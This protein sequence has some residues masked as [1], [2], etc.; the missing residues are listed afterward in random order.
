MSVTSIAIVASGLWTG[1]TSASAAPTPPTPVTPTTVKA[2]PGLA[3]IEVTWK[4]SV[5]K[6][7]TFTVTS[8]PI[9]K[10]CSVV[11]QLRCGVSV[12]DSTPWQFHVTASIGSTSSAPST[13]TAPVRHRILLILAGQSNAMGAESYPVDPTTGVNYLAPPYT[14]GADSLSTLSWYPWLV[15]PPKHPGKTGQVPLDTAQWLSP[16][17]APKVQIFGPEIGWARQV[18]SD[19]GQAVSIVK[20][21]AIGSLTVDWNPATPSNDFSVLLYRAIST[22]TDDAKSGQLDTIGAVAWY[23]GESDASTPADAAAYRANLTAFV[24]AFRADLPMDPA[25]PV[26]LV[27]ESMAGYL[28]FVQDTGGCATSVDCA[29]LQLGDSEVRSADDWVAGNLPHVTAVDTVDLPRTGVLVHLSNLGDLAV[30]TRIAQASDRSM[31]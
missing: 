1:V 14:N 31:P 27:K 20:V 5:R 24:T 6:G 13:L 22:M 25:V 9:G 8:I 2:T 26:V 4:S 30:G 11:A 16:I 7:V 21:A 29:A 23:Q 18:Y 3:S 19:T 10:T 28:G 12:T 15:A 17:G